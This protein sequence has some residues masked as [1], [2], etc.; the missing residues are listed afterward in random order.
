MSERQYFSLRYAIPG[1][2]F[3]L[4][5]IGINFV[6]LLKFLEEIPAFKDSFGAFLAF[7]SLFSGSA[8]GFLISQFW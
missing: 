4:I 5:L 7:F 3:I 6:P 8:I 2:A 1:F